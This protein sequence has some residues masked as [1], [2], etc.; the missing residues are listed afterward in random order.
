MTCDGGFAL[1]VAGP[2]GASEPRRGRRASG[3]LG[4][5]SVSGPK[6]DGVGNGCN[7]TAPTTRSASNSKLF[8]RRNTR[9]SERVYQ[10]TDPLKRVHQDA[11][12]GSRVHPDQRERRIVVVRARLQQGT[13]ERHGTI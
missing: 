12:D 3:A 9:I 7:A 2:S 1:S 10:R 13:H 6:G 11:I 5:A 8:S 4:I